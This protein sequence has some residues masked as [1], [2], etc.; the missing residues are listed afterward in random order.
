MQKTTFNTILIV[1]ILLLSGHLLLYFNLDVG[2]PPVQADIIIVPEGPGT[3]R[4]Q[5]SVELLNQGYSKSNKIVVSPFV[6]EEFSTDF[7]FHYYDLYGATS[8]EIIQEN[9]AS[10]TWQN[11]THTLEMMQELGCTSALIV[12]SDYHTRRVHLAY[13]R[14]NE[15]Y[16]FDLTFVS[17]HPLNEKDAPIPYWKHF[18]NKWYALNEIPKLYGY[19][20]G[21]YHFIDL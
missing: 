2:S 3:E 10:S 11:A 4:A 20:L 18:R 21:L 12:S 7:S 16:G 17:A 13:E 8:D 5:K 14:V 19:Q 15:D 9:E 6:N 1:S